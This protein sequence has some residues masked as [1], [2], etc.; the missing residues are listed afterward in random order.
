MRPIKLE[1][2]KG[3]EICDRCGANEEIPFFCSKKSESRDQF[4]VDWRQRHES[5]FKNCPACKT[6]FESIQDYNKERE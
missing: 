4:F 5:C 2:I 6:D 1:N 3:V